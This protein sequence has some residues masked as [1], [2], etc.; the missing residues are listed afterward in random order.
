VTVRQLSLHYRDV[1]PMENDDLTET[2][3]EAPAEVPAEVPADEIDPVAKTR[4]SLRGYGFYLIGYAVGSAAIAL[5]FAALGPKYG[6]AL[7]TP[8]WF[9]YILLISVYAAR[10]QVPGLLRVHGL[11]LA[12]WAVIWMTALLGSIPLDQAGSWWV[13]AGIAMALPPLITRF[14]VLRRLAGPFAQRA[15]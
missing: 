1:E 2:P 8:I 15:G 7:L 14:G 11:M 6:A 12:A 9:V 3:A 4:R 10:Q 13:A 5:G